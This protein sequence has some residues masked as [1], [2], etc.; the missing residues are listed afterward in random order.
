MEGK[1]G[2]HA[3]VYCT[4]L[5]PNWTSGT[6]ETKI[7]VVDILHP[8]VILSNLTLILLDCMFP[9]IIVL[10]KLSYT[11]NLLNDSCAFKN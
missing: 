6:G 3:Y 11:W 1:G 4:W 10:K 5:S 2:E 7:G 8:R 9:A